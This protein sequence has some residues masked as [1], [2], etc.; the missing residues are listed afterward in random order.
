MNLPNVT[1]ADIPAILDQEDIEIR[2][3]DDPIW[4]HALFT[5]SFNS[6]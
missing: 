1:S 2:S 3:K 5:K 4:Y 6:I